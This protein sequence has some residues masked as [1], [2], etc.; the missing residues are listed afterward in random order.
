MQP[1]Y[2]RQSKTKLVTTILTIIVIA[3][4]VVFADHL[5]SSK[6][7]ASTNLASTTSQTTTPTAPTTSSTAASTGSSTTSTA[8][9]SST[10]SSGFKDGTYSASSS[11]YVPDGNENIKLTVAVRNGVITN[12]T[13]AN[14]QGDPTSA[15]FQQD[16]ASNF[17]S[18]VVGKKIASLQ[19]GVISGA[20]DTSQGFNDA[21]SQIE[22]QAQA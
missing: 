19:I 12:A 13:V 18:Y 6:T 15:F 9:S 4:I 17:K 7:L 10:S 16:F 11:Y 5:K 21:L 3:G 22:S 20:S 14:S 2:E 8:S 1:T